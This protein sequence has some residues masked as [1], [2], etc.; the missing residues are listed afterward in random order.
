MLFAPFQRT[1]ECQCRA[2]NLPPSYQPSVDFV[3]SC[4]PP[5]SL[6]IRERWHR[7][8]NAQISIPRVILQ[9][10]GGLRSTHAVYSIVVN[11]PKFNFQYK[12]ARRFSEFTGRLGAV[13]ARHSMPLPEK[14]FIRSLAPAHLSSRQ[15][16][17]EACLKNLLRSADLDCKEQE[18]VL[19]F[20][21]FWPE[22]ARETAPTYNP[23]QARVP[24]AAAAPIRI[25]HRLNQ[26]RKKAE[27][28]L[29]TPIQ[30]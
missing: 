16:L 21:G 14:T 13:M 23:V 29:G 26:D 28:F 2:A 9:G 17:L 24:S 15:H 8:R 18:V 22:Q 20:L 12:A 30:P 5:S 4:L 3:P 7:L 6:A 19:D 11:E 10:K 1:L 27:G 25:R